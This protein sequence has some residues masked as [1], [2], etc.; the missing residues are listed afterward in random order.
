MSDDNPWRSPI[1][2]R[3][4][5]VMGLLDRTMNAMLALKADD[6]HQRV[7][8]RDAMHEVD[9]AMI[10]IYKL[11]LARGEL[12]DYLTAKPGALQGEPQ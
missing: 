4:Q 2:E 3:A 5:T 7:M 10:H 8:K 12:P 9:M 1:S 11:Q 6:A